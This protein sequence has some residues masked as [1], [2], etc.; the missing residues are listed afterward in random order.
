MRDRACVTPVGSITERSWEQALAAVGKPYKLPGW[1]TVC[2]DL[3]ALKRT[4]YGPE[5][6]SASA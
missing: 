4:L 2:G 6:R 3:L 5:N 1:S